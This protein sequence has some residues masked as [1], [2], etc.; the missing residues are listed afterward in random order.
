MTERKVEEYFTKQVKKHGA[1]TRK[2][3]SPGHRG[4]P[5]RIVLKNGQCFFVELKRPGGKPRPN[6]V[7]EHTRF[8]KQG[9]RVA[10]LDSKELVDWWIKERL[11]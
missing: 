1:L 10:I 2:F 7:A 11:P 5:D 9:F 3:T 6:Q 4:V 8:E